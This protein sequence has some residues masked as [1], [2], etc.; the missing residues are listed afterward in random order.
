MEF[1]WGLF[2]FLIVF[3]I[4]VLLALKWVINCKRDNDTFG[5]PIAT[6]IFIIL[7]FF[8]SFVVFDC[9]SSELPQYTVVDNNLYIQNEDCTY[10][11]ASHM[12]LGIPPKTEQIY[13]TTNKD[14][15]LITVHKDSGDE[16]YKRV[17]DD[18][19]LYYA[20]IQD[21]RTGEY[22]FEYLGKLKD[23]IVIKKSKIQRRTE[24]NKEKQ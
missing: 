2:T 23:G 18:Q 24:N 6:I 5:F 19:H 10:T 8:Y 12:T 14:N 21:S 1:R 4:I 15:D 13:I 17:Y 20:P 22:I 16:Q 7:L 3:L 9:T 11:L